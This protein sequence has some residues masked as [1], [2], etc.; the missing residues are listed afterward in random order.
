M[1]YLGAIEGY[2]LRRLPYGNN[3][4]ANCKKHVDQVKTED[5]RLLKCPQS[6]SGCTIAVSVLTGSSNIRW[7]TATCPADPV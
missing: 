1:S 4:F 6:N 5:D 7:C 2:R 3:K